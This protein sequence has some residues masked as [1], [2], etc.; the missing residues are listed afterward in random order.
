[1]CARWIG[2]GVISLVLATCGAILAC[3]W[4]VGERAPF[5]AVRWVDR[6]PVVRIGDTWIRLESIDDVE[7]GDLMLDV[8]RR[9]GIRWKSAFSDRFLHVRRSAGLWNPLW[10]Y[11]AGRDAGTDQPLQ[12]RSPMTR[13]RRGSFAQV[14]AQCPCVSG[15]DAWWSRACW[16]SRSAVCPPAGGRVARRRAYLLMAWRNFV[17]RR[18]ER[19]SGALTPAMTLGLTD[20]PWSWDLKVFLPDRDQQAGHHHA[21]GTAIDSVSPWKSPRSAPSPASAFVAG[22]KRC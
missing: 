21:N 17:K 18:T 3:P 20:R 12:I 14:P 4:I 19:R 10:C 22:T 5:D 9:Y 2:Y 13:D 8:R 6:L 1:M 16:S 11:L 7:I 15:S